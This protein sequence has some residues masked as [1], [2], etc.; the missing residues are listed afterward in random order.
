MRGE[1]RTAWA[2][3]Q[4]AGASPHE[5]LEHEPVIIETQVRRD[6]VSVL[7]WPFHPSSRFRCDV[8]VHIERLLLATVCPSGEG[9]NLYRTRFLLL[10][11]K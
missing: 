4:T 3:A 5:S 1:D 2:R 6:C 11:F 9:K 8:N 7:P 10:A